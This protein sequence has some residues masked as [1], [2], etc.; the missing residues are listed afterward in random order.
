M[1]VSIKNFCYRLWYHIKQKRMGKIMSYTL[2]TGVTSGIGL[3]LAREFAEHGSSLILVARRTDAVAK[4]VKEL[5][6]K[7]PSQNFES[8]IIDLSKEHAGEDL[9]LQVVE[10]GYEVDTLVNNA[11]IGYVGK[12]E[13]ISM[14]DYEEMMR[15]NMGTVAATCHAFIPMLKRNG[16]GI[17]NVASNGAFHPGPYTANYYAT[18][19]Y[20]LHLS[21]GIRMEL[22]KDGVKVCA[23]CPGATVSDFCRKAGKR[24]IKGSMSAEAVAKAAYRG[25]MRNKAV[26]IPGIMNKVYMIAPRKLRSFAIYISQ[27]KLAT[28]RRPD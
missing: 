18:K 17:L 25:Y 15:I 10:S 28:N 9:Y 7:Y 23:L 8:I 16:G 5:K 27:Q 1:F 14:A 12:Y 2:I 4:V 11:G 21:E 20:V 26:I 24:Q 22:K 19:A 13:T 3:A 6:E